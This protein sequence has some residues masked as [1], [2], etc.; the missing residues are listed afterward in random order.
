[1]VDKAKAPPPVVEPVTAPQGAFILPRTGFYCLGVLLYYHEQKPL[2]RAYTRL[3][4]TQLYTRSRGGR[5]GGA[6]E[7]RRQ[8]D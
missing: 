8:F 7:E 1:M 3:H 6:A 4:G 2:T 5:I